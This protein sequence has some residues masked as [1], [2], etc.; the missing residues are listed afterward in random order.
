LASRR[1][2]EQRELILSEIFLP[3]HPQDALQLL[4]VALVSEDRVT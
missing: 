3:E 4:F 2:A 1:F